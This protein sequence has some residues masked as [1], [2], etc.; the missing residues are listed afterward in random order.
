METWFAKLRAKRCDKP[1]FPC[2][3]LWCSIVVHW[4]DSRNKWGSC[5]QNTSQHT[6]L[7]C[8][9]KPNNFLSFLRRRRVYRWFSSCRPKFWGHKDW[10]GKES[11]N[12]RL[13]SGWP[14][15]WKSALIR[16]WRF[17]R[18][19]QCR[20]K[21]SVLYWESSE[22]ITQKAK[23][24]QSHKVQIRIGFRTSRSWEDNLQLW[25]ITGG[26]LWCKT[27][28]NSTRISSWWG[29]LRDYH[30][31]RKRSTHL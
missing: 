28:Y 9:S 1:T 10:K 29:I 16:K 24:L 5:W 18:Q 13:T 17:I 3:S 20:R 26:F 11:Q 22:E 15:K 19:L 30:P 23:K 12:K 31:P 4:Q 21:H 2:T 6:C 14:E 8:W 7:Q 27:R 25:F